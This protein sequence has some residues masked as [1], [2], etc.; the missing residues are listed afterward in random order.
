MDSFALPLAVLRNESYRSPVIQWIARP[1]RAAS[2]N[3]LGALYAAFH[4]R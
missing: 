4:H 3:G 2:R 1:Y